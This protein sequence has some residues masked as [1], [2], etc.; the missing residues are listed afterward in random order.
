MAKKRKK[1]ENE[2][3][4][5]RKQ[6]RL[7]RHERENMRKVWIAAAT[8]IV[9]VLLVVLYGFVEEYVVKPNIPAAVVNGEKINRDE[10]A[11]YMAYHQLSLEQQLQQMEQLQKQLDPE[12]KSSLFTSQIQQLK[13]QLSAPETFA[14]QTLDGMIDNVLIRQKAKAMNISVS[15]AEVEKAIQDFFG[16]VPNPPTPTPTPSPMPTPTVGP[17]TS[18]PT[19]LPTAT[20]TPTPLTYEGYQVRYKNYVNYLQRQ[21]GLTEQEFHQIFLDQLLRDRVL[22]AVTKDVPTTE[23]AV[24]ARHILIRPKVPTPAAVGAGTPTPTPDP[25]L[26]QFA[27]QA[28]KVKAETL[29]KQLRGGA[30]FAEVAKK[31]SDD[32]GSASVGGDLGWFSRG[33]MVKPFEN[34]AFSL[35]VNQ[36]SDVIKT[37]YGYHI[38]Q[39]LEKDPK[40]PRSKADIKKDKDKE[41]Q[42]WLSKV[43]SEAKIKKSFT[44]SMLPPKLLTPVP[45][46]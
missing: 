45:V 21:T 39:V 36:I 46:R 44:L 12:G 30:D 17:G 31:N 28:A 13:T 8:L 26:Q 32:P 20:V 14:K 1:E 16:Y 15:D 37:N 33:K 7:S 22:E 18:T 9:L 19:P 41:F 6:A 11:H 34:A 40:H 5:T 38:V 3:Q 23:E 43:R 24:H 27:D 4:I 42:R 2:R 29:L 10:L 35:G 25:A